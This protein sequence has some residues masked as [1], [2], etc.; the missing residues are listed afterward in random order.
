MKDNNKKKGKS[1]LS[2]TRFR[3][4]IYLFVSNPVSKCI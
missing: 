4:F 1:N 3:K 2:C